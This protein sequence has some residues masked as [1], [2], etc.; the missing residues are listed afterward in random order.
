VPPLWASPPTLALGAHREINVVAADGSTAWPVSTHPLHPEDVGVTLTA[1][2]R[3]R[4][5]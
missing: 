2:E 5:S 1:E 3:R 4:S